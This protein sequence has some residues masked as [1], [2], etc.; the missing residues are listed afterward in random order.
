MHGCLWG[1]E[2]G[3]VYFVLKTK[4]HVHNPRLLDVGWVARDS[5]VWYGG[6]GG[7]LIFWANCLDMWGFLG[8]AGI[9]PLLNRPC[10]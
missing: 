10:T 3:S 2:G 5:G 7:S 9:P 8:L 1:G 4:N 6:G